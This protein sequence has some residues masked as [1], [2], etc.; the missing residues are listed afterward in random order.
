MQ[1]ITLFNRK[2]GVGKTTF[3]AIIGAGLAMRGFKVLLIDADNQHNLTKS[4]GLPEQAGFFKFVKWADKNTPDFVDVRNVVLRVPESLCPDNLFIVPG[5]NDTWGIPGSMHMTDIVRNLTQRLKLVEK[6]FD[7]VL[8]DT[9]PSA[10]T[11]HDGIGLVSDWIICPTDPEAFGA[12][13]GTLS[14]VEHMAKIR[15]QALAYGYDKAKMLGIIPNKYRANTA[16]HK[17]V[18]ETL[19]HGQLDENGEVVLDGFGPLVWEPIPVRTAIP[20]MQL[21]RTMLMHDAP[22]LKT[23]VQLWRLIDRVIEETK[24]GSRV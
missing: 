9:Q 18:V 4:I 17:Y 12:F 6:I 24:V 11:L 14:T 8:I 1:V 19:T 2:G 20:E 21:Y 23:N 15:G 13:E 16:L 7:Y 5:S 10:T 3:T 22:S